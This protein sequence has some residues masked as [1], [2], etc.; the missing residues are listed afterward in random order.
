MMRFT[1][2]L[3]IG[4]ALAAAAGLSACGGGDA[5]DAATSLGLTRPVVR[6][7]HAIP[8]GPAVDVAQNG[9]RNTALLNKSYEF[10]SKYFSVDSG[11]QTFSFLQAGTNTTL[12]TTTFGMANGHKYTVVAIPSRTGPDTVVIDDPFE[13]QLLSDKARVRTLNASANASNVD[14]YVTAPTVDINTVTPTMAGVAF[15]NSVPAGGQD[16]IYLNGGTY[17]LRITPAGTKT[18]IFDSGALKID[19]DADWLLTTIPV[20][21]IGAFVPNN[22]KVLLAKSDDDGQKAVELV[23]APQ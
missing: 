8:N 2:T 22:I 13:K 6:V 11:T 23:N 14:V 12:A 9:T 4:L 20:D 1:K 5:N 10:V 21:G 16:S 18:P 3:A 19:N 15:H 7:M 17:R